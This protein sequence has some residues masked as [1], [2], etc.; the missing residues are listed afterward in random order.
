[1]RFSL[2]TTDSPQDYCWPDSQ[3]DKRS[4][5]SAV[6]LACSLPHKHRVA[7]LYSATSVLNTRT[8]LCRELRCWCNEG[9]CGTLDPDK[10]AACSHAKVESAAG[11][12]ISLPTEPF[13]PSFVHR[14]PIDPTCRKA[15]K[16]ETERD[17]SKTPSLYQGTNIYTLA[18]KLGCSSIRLLRQH[19]PKLPSASS[20][21]S[22]LEM[23]SAQPISWAVYVH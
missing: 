18:W 9:S 21:Y 8:A 17:S 14:K 23:H 6:L 5:R 1:M 15:I 16:M 12:E 10:C 4:C 11:H 20:P 13:A 22:A 2:Q 19:G 7:L 3:L